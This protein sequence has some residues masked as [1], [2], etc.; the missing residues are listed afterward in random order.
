[1]SKPF[2][3]L[4]MDGGGLRGIVPVLILQKIEAITGKRIRDMFHL[5]AGTSTGGLIAC[6]LSV[7]DDGTKPLYNLQDV[8]DMYINHGKEIFPPAAKDL[9][10][11][12]IGKVDSLF[13]PGYNPNGLDR[14]LVQMFGNRTMKNCTVPIM[15]CS[16]DLKN[17]EPVFFKSRY[18]QGDFADASL[19]DVCRATSAAPTYFP[20]YEMHY[21]CKDRICV[22]G[23][24]Y[25][26]NPGMAAV[27]EISKFGTDP[28]YKTPVDFGFKD[29]FVLSLGT[30]TYKFDMSKP[31]YAKGGLV[32]WA[33]RISDVMMQSVN[34]STIYECKEMLAPDQYFRVSIE[35]GDS[36]YSDMADSSDATR[37]YLIDQVRTQVSESADVINN[38]T[39]FLKKAGAITSANVTA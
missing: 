13:A 2:L 26:N 19:H 17:N 1:M 27:S 6:A 8:A 30:G 33:T 4:S 36:K 29:I 23:G 37:N 7:S 31:R 28:Y 24:V 39:A 35:I 14:I 18:T 11:K 25:I 12:L 3:I 15:A 32:S 22:D 9:Y 34:A 38:L 10:Q 21:D 16:Y 20:A 5:L